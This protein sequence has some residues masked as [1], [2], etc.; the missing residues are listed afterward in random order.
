[1]WVVLLRVH[2]PHDMWV[3]AGIFKEKSNAEA[4]RKLFIQGGYAKESVLIASTV[5]QYKLEIEE[6]RMRVQDA[7][8]EAEAV[9][10]SVER[11]ESDSTVLV[12]CLEDLA[13][14]LR[15]KQQD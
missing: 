14:T 12:E 2:S 11:A 5:P 8:S 4:R 13:E 7:I 15:Q 1:M 9:Q 6:Y 3:A 10:Q